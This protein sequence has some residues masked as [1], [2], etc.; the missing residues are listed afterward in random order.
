MIDQQKVVQAVEDICSTGC[1][2][3]KAIILTLEQGNP[4][5][6]VNNFTA[7]ELNILL[8]ELKSIMAVYEKN[9]LI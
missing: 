9:S 7:E 3:V 8:S 1:I 5:E 4:V 2:S 6:S